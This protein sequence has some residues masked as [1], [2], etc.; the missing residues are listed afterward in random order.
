MSKNFQFVD[1]FCSQDVKDYVIN[2][3]S[4][5]LG[6]LVVMNC[7]W[8]LERMGRHDVI[9][10]VI[11]MGGVANVGDFNPLNTKKNILEKI[12]QK[13]FLILYFC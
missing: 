9:Y 2:L 10:D 4:F 12:L 8:E 13:F 11:L 7:I 1:I 3:M 6:T 5:S